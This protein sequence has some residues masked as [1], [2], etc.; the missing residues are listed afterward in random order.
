[1]ILRDTCPRCSPDAIRDFL[2]LRPGFRGACPERSRRASSRLPLFTHH[3]YCDETLAFV[4]LIL[5]CDRS[6]RS[7]EAGV[8][9]LNLCTLISSSDTAVGWNEGSEFQRRVALRST[10]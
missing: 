3:V 7:G 2:P 1:M 4:L 10:Q 6:P 9:T 8:S 5:A